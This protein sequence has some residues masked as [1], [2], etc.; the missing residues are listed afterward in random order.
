MKN[1]TLS[2]SESKIQHAREVARS[3]GA[4]LNQLFR[5]WIDTLDQRNARTQ[6]YDSFMRSVE[7]HV[8]T[9]GRRYSREAMNE[10]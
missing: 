3:R 2:A 5:Q 7:G 9:G 4:T 6:A 1:I 10:R 8:D